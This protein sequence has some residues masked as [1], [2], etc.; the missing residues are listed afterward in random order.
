MKL[1]SHELIGQTP[2]LDGGA[3][4]SLWEH[5]A[6]INQNKAALDA[7]KHTVHPNLAQSANWQDPEGR[8]LIWWWPRKG[9]ADGQALTVLL[10]K[11]ERRR[12]RAFLQ[13]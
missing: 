8:S 6:S 13:P 1:H 5:Q 9:P 7:D 3:R 2:L 10:T 12:R 4:S 11:L